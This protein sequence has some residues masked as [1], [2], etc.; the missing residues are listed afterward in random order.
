MLITSKQ[1]S[2]DW[3]TNKPVGFICLERQTK[4]ENMGDVSAGTML[5]ECQR[6]RETWRGRDEN[7]QRQEN[8]WAN[9]ICLLCSPFTWCLLVCVCVVGG[10]A[11]VVPALSGSSSSHLQHCGSTGQHGCRLQQGAH[12]GSTHSTYLGYYGHHFFFQLKNSYMC[13]CFKGRIML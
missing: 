4:E 5:R 2:H 1:M 10:H 11:A 6:E 12:T 7:R 13:I 3:I 8:Y 9:I